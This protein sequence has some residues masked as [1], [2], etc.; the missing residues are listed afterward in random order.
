[1]EVKYLTSNTVAPLMDD[2]ITYPRSEIIG[3]IRTLNL[4]VVSMDRIG[5]ATADKSETEQALTLCRFFDKYD[6]FQKLASARRSLHD[7]F[8][9]ELGADG[10]D[11][12]ERDLQDLKYWSAN[13]ENNC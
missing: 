6:V 5:S 1:M 7:A 11:E 13:D 12:L 2:S 4:L 3:V 10:M 9:Y 8:S